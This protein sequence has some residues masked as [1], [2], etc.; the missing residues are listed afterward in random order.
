MGPNY[1][2]KEPMKTTVSQ[3]TVALRHRPPDAH[4]VSPY[5][6]ILRLPHPISRTRPRMSL[7]SRAAQFAP[8]AALTGFEND[9]AET[10]LLVQEC[11]DRG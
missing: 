2:T 9:I 8:F 5:A 7:H 6:D 11:Y 10:E 3:I 4:A 1:L